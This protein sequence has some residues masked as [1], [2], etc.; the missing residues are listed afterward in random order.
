MNPTVSSDGGDKEVP[1]A[2]SECGMSL[3]HAVEW[4]PTKSLGEE[5]VLVAYGIF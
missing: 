5:L 1:V 2:A 4:W 3:S